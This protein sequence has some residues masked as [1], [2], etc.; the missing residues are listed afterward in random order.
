MRHILFMYKQ[1]TFR[2][3][4]CRMSSCCSCL[5]SETSCCFIIKNNS[6]G[7][8]PVNYQTT[9]LSTVFIANTSMVVDFRAKPTDF[10]VLSSIL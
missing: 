5:T 7:S 8:P 1:K 10:T 3:N 4:L 6:N 2:K 9:V